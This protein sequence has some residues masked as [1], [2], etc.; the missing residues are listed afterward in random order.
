MVF[1]LGVEQRGEVVNV[2]VRGKLNCAVVW[3]GGYTDKG[4]ICTTMRAVKRVLA[5]DLLF[6]F[7]ALKHN[8]MCG[9][10][11]THLNKHAFSIVGHSALMIPSPVLLRICPLQNSK[12]PG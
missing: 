10:N 2:S 5:L 8:D 4:G 9:L 6:S 1:C 3:A 11:E 7:L 12:R